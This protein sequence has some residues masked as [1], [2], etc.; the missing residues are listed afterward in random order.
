MSHP[1][2][3]GLIEHPAEQSR[4]RPV[5]RPGTLLLFPTPRPYADIWALQRQ[6][7]A[8]RTADLRSDLLLL[9]EHEPIYTMGRTTQPT[10]WSGNERLLHQLGAALQPVD[11]GGSITYHGPGQLIGYPIVKLSRRGLGPK[12]Y[13]RMLEQ[14]LIDVLLLSGIDGYRME[15]KP[16]VWVRLDGAEAKLASIGVRLDRGVTMHGFALNVDLDLSPFSYIVPCGLDRCRMTSMAEVRQMPVATTLV[17]Q[18]IA[19]CFADTFN[20]EWKGSSHS[21]DQECSYA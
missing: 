21:P 10:H 6:L 14:V 5:C 17:A 13:V 4:S 9:L 3:T 16:G 12:S 2:H 19:Q 1:D 20:V 7:H 8:E 18:Q 15:R 11:R